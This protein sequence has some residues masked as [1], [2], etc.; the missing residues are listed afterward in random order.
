MIALVADSSQVAEARRIAF[1]LARGL[2]CD[3]TEM[4]R[5]A[6]VATELATNLLKHA[7]A[8]AIVVSEFADADGTGVELLSLDKGPGIADMARALED[9]YSTAGS[10]GTGLGAIRRQANAFA[11][12]SRPGLGTAVMARLCRKSA[13][14]T[15]ADVVVGAVVDPFPGETQCGDGWNLGEAAAGPSL[16]MIDGSGHGMAAA[17]AAQ[18]AVLAFQQRHDR[19][20]VHAMEDIHRALAPTRGGAAALARIDRGAQ[21]VRF[22]GVGNIA[23]AVVSEGTTKRMVSHNGIVG[24]VAPRIREFTYPYKGDPLLVL[25]SDGLTAKWDFD[26]Y[27]GLTASHPSLVAG[28]LFRDHRRSRDDAAVVALRMRS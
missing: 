2:G 12:Y 11:V 16:F 9:G 7:G 21:T 6:L 17:V 15:G 25:H 19:D 27:P 10:P 8:G 5:I 24:H 22:V 20:C 13:A 3:E 14:R 26:A 18:A 1:A 4:A 23:A 28:V